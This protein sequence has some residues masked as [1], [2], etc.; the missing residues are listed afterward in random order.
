MKRV[1]LSRLIP[2]ASPGKGDAFDGGFSGGE[3]RGLRLAGMTLGRCELLSRITCQFRPRSRAY[4]SA[5]RQ[6]SKPPATT[7]SK[8]ASNA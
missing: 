3:G 8:L 6:Y 1:R 5:E 2:G 7:D 4:A